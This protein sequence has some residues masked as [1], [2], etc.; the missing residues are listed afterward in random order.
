MSS[1]AEAALAAISHGTSSPLGQAAVASLVDAVGRSLD[2]VPVRG[3][4]V[5]VQEPGVE[6]TLD[7]IPS[8]TAAVVVPLLLSAGY[9]VHVD[10]TRALAA[11]RHTSILA[12][13]LGPDGRIIDVLIRR[14][15][16]LGLRASDRVIL[17]CAGSSDS[18]AV[19]DCH[20]VGRLLGDSL[21]MPVRVA[22]LSAAT[23]TLPDA[24]VSERAAAPCSRVIV[25]T[26]LLA[27]GY[28]A[29]RAAASQAD[30]V[31]PPL[32]L[33]HEDPD[34]AIVR[35]VLDRYAA[36]AARL[37]QETEVRMPGVGLA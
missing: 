29:D 3:G 30:L 14:L 9:H 2:C 19:D 10:L 25:S 4:F 27:P 1:S 20:E 11:S 8:D 7:S 34:P 35:I 18:R 21:G 13:A 37:A 26:Y 36:A 23:P 17:A 5:D 15:L 6:A 12:E 31:A 32:L 16:S 24:V 28:F 33:A 22:F